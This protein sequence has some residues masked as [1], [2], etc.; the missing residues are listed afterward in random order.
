MSTL[1][2]EL[3]EDPG[4]FV[5]GGMSRDKGSTGPF[6][7]MCFSGHPCT[8]TVG[9]AATSSVGDDRMCYVME[10]RQRRSGG[11]RH[12]SYVF[13]AWGLNSE[14]G[15]CNSTG[16]GG[17]GRGE[18][19]SMT[20]S[21]YTVNLARS[22]GLGGDRGCGT[23]AKGFTGWALG[24]DRAVDG[25]TNT[26]TSVQS[27]Q[28]AWVDSPF[29]N[30]ALANPWFAVDLG[31]TGNQLSHVVIKTA[32]WIDSGGRW[33]ANFPLSIH[34]GDSQDWSDNAPCASNVSGF[35]P[36]SGATLVSLN[37]SSSLEPVRL[38]ERSFVY[39]GHPGLPASVIRFSC[40]ATGRWVHVVLNGTDFLTMGE[41]EV[42]GN[43]T[44]SSPR[45][46][47]TSGCSRGTYRYNGVCVDCPKGWTTSTLPLPANAGPEEWTGC[48]VAC[49]PSM[50]S[51]SSTGCK[52]AW[53]KGA[54]WPTSN[55]GVRD[56]NAICS[57]AGGKTC[58]KGGI[59]YAWGLERALQVIDIL[60]ETA[61]C[62]VM[63]AVHRAYNSQDSDWSGLSKRTCGA[64][65]TGMCNYFSDGP[66]YD[67]ASGNP[68]FYNSTE[69]SG[70]TCTG[71]HGDM[72]K[73]C[74]CA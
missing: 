38:Q 2:K 1:L 66:H 10:R 17:R 8:E 11:K 72:N 34:V 52:G 45:S 28:A 74:V 16:R 63:N 71:G 68:S 24:P 43:R 57:N 70:G 25:N 55:S 37:G 12:V 58:Q 62:G 26:W 15:L 59:E 61:S 18:G 39:T 29:S 31:T 7:W 27:G 22:C 33:K 14:L 20:L 65:Y 32:S 53:Y 44:A 23:S 35:G 73:Y 42:Y 48:S 40:R 46:P 47:G 9:I 41:V 69:T 54:S 49:S 56:C 4:L 19:A 67:D 3:A 51:D 60:G 5:S 30:T 36:D 13:H 64:C 21:N 50:L 6:T